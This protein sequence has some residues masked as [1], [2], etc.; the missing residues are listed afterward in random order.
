MI[1]DNIKIIQISNDLVMTFFGHYE[2]SLEASGK[3]IEE[4]H[5]F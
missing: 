1:K 3:Y 5:F 2:I 4:N